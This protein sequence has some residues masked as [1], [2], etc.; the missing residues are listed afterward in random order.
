MDVGIVLHIFQITLIRDLRNLRRVW[1]LLL[2]IRDF[3]VVGA[4]WQRRSRPC[5]IIAWWVHL[6]TLLS[7]F[8]ANINSA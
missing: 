6:G 7:A 2:A 1:S 5:M 3:C 8:P 4:G